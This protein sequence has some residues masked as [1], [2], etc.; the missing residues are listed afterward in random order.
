MKLF[1]FSIEI[2]HCSQ[3]LNQYRTIRS[4]LIFSS[5][6]LS[7]LIVQKLNSVWFCELRGPAP[8]QEHKFHQLPLEG[9]FVNVDFEPTSRHMLVSTRPSLRSNISTNSTH[10]VCDLVQHYS[11]AYG[12]NMVT[13]N[14][15][16]T[17]QVTR[18]IVIS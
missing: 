18:L 6:S 11:E 15:I 13:T 8:R 16:R 9:P 4:Y 14:L 1:F 2:I 3:S 10:M 5:F 17:Y 7:G 12:G